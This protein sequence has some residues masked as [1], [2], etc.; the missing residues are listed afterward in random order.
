MNTTKNNLIILI[1]LFWFTSKT[2]PVVVAVLM[3]LPIMT[4]NVTKG[5]SQTDKSL[6]NMAIGF[7]LTKK[8]I[9]KYLE[10]WNKDIEDELLYSDKD[11]ILKEMI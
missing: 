8:Q 4:A 2:V 1:T 6:E 9:F 11:K 5:F 7:Q 3:A 10:G